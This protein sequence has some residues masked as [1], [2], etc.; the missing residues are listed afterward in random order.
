MSAANKQRK[1]T[2]DWRLGTGRSTPQASSLK[3]QASSASTQ[4]F[5]RWRIVL[6][7]AC[8]ALPLLGFAVAGALWLHDRSWLGWASLAFA[9]G[10]TL[11]FVLFRRWLRG[12]RAVLPQPSLQ[13]PMNFST[14]RSGLGGGARL[15]KTC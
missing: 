10:Q 5:S 6:L 15:S 14:R 4:H 1:E 11:A 9:V 13:P 8:F 12:D 3:P 7:V 2:G